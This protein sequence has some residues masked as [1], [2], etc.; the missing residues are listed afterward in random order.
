MEYC[1]VWGDPENNY[2][3]DFQAHFIKLQAY[4][5]ECQHTVRYGGYRANNLVGIE[6]E[7]TNLD[8][9]TA[10][11]RAEVT[12]LTKYN[13]T[14]TSQ[15]AEYANNLS[16]REAENAALHKTISKING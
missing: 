6:E 14:L 15:V 4:Q 3:K 9:A 5:Q 16:T 12:N 10:Y 13:V 2:Q 7:F 1:F 8:Q 11:D